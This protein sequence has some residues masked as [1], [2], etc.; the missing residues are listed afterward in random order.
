MR[1]PKRRGLNKQNRINLSERETETDDRFYQ[2]EGMTL[3]IPI[4]ASI[5]VRHYI[6]ADRHN[7]ELSSIFV[8]ITT[9]CY[10]KARV[11]EQ[12]SFVVGII[13]AQHE[14]NSKGRPLRY[15]QPWNYVP[16]NMEASRSEQLAP[17]GVVE[18]CAGENYIMFLQSGTGPAGWPLKRQGSQSWSRFCAM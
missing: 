9:T 14:R 6:I 13:D 1:R 2:K 15:G 4:H 18:L 12:W 8:R 7:T 11:P 3:T 10:T 17:G 16:S 5:P